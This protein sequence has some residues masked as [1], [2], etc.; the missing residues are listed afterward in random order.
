MVDSTLVRSAVFG[1]RNVDNA[2]KGHVGKSAVAAGQIRNALFEAKKLDGVL[3]ETASTAI[4]ALKSV[5]KHGKALEVA[6]KAV[7]L[8][9]QYVNPLICVS[10]GLDVAMADDKEKAFVE[11]T[12]GL[13]TM[14]AAEKLMKKHLD[15]VVKIKGIDKIAA[16]VSEVAGKTKY[17]KFIPG[18]IHGLTFVVG[19]CTAYSVG[20]NFGTTLMGGKT[21][22]NT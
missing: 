19:S 11:N 22:E 20:K 9:G 1:V 21:Q 2:Q 4:E 7:N 18:I 17:G 10:A 12:A 3:G 14:F 15:E 16:K 13:G 8:A 6:G 5:T